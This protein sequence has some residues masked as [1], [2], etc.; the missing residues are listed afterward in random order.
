MYSET[1]GFEE[2]CVIFLWVVRSSVLPTFHSSK[3]D[4]MRFCN[5]RLCVVV[6]A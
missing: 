6:V 5:A 4:L 1:R 2:F 3:L